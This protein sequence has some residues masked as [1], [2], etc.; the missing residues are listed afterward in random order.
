MLKDKKIILGITGSISAYKSAEILSL[1][2]KKGADVSVVM[3]ESATRFIQPLTFATLSERPV[4]KD[5]FP[6]ENTPDVRHISLAKWA[7]LILIAPATANIIGKIAHGIADDLLT[8]IVIASRAKIMIAPAM[9][10]NMISN[11]MYLENCKK[12]KSIGFDFIESEYG[13][14]ACGD[15]GMG[16]LANTNTIISRL[17]NFFNENDDFKNKTILITASCTRE[18]IDKVRFISNYSTGK[19]GFALAK[20]A[21]ERGARVILISGPNQLPPVKVEKIINV[22]TAEEMKKEVFNYLPQADIVISAAAIADFRP[23]KFVYGKI[24]KD[25][26]KKMQIEMEKTTDILAEV[27]KN[28]REKILIGFAAESD[29]LV[30]NATEKLKNKNL[31]LIV[32]NDIL[33][34]ETGFASDMNSAKIINKDGVIKEIPVMYKSEMAKYVLDEILK[35][36]YK[37]IDKSDKRTK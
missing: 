27:G 34:A 36:L 3:T 33:N 24:K 6:E 18:P 29:K 7:D 4:M 37:G 5:M 21:E 8:S 35:I 17:S 28:K 30:E 11:Q 19:M 26:L 23:K 12:L 20:N 16:R 9:N 31:D 13:I 22:E 15:T 1:I 10:K 32:A 2:K 14:L 25:N